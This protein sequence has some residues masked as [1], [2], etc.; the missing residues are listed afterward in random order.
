MIE[1]GQFKDVFL[2]LSQQDFANIVDMGY[3]RKKRVK[4]KF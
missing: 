4:D 3:E 1:R 2:R